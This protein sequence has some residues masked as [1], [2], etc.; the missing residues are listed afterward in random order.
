MVTNPVNP[1]ILHSITPTTNFFSKQFLVTGCL[2]AILLGIVTGYLLATKSPGPATGGTGGAKTTASSA[3]PPKEAGINDKKA[4]PDCAEGVIQQ[5]GISGEGT[6]HL[7]REGGASRTAYIT[8]SIID[9]D[10][11]IDR[12]VQVCGQTIAAKKAPWLM[13]IGYIKLLD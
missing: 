9:L 8:S 2:T 6:H 7:V 3:S 5:G 11:Y 1:S 12:K 10:Q 4:S 13:D